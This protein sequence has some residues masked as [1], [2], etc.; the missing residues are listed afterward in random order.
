MRSRRT[1]PFAFGE[2][3]VYAHKVILSSVSIATSST[4]RVSGYSDVVVY[5]M[6]RYIYGS[7]L[8]EDYEEFPGEE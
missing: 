7:P 8:D 5:A 3:K 1:L 6:L 4:Y 2:E